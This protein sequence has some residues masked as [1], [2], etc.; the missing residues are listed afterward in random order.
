MTE[1]AL[2]YIPSEEIVSFVTQNPIDWLENPKKDKFYYQAITDDD[3][4]KPQF[5]DRSRYTVKDF[6]ALGGFGDQAGVTPTPAIE[7]F[8]NL[9]IERRSLFTQYEYMHYCW[10]KWESWIR[11]LTEFQKY[12]VRAKL[13]RN[14][15]PSAIDSLHVWAML[16]DTGAFEMCLMSATEDAIGKSDLVLRS[17]SREFRIALQINTSQSRNDRQHKKLNRNNDEP[18]CIEVW[19]SLDEPKAPGNKRWYRKTDVIGAI[20][21]KAY[22]TESQLVTA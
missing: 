21:S 3:K 8:L 5:R 22:S 2:I 20:T 13:Y 4:E 17:G 15:Y 9:L 12:G 19:L 10:G 14:F 18:D 1:R 16:A 7:E 6:Y 11:G